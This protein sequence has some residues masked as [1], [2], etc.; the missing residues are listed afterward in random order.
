MKRFRFKCA[1]VVLLFLCIIPQPGIAE[2]CT[3]KDREYAKFSDNYYDPEEAYHFGK[4]IQALVKKKDLE[5]IFSYVDGE[6]NNG[7]RRSFAYSKGFDGTFPAEWIQSVSTDTPPCSPVGWRGF[8]LGSGLI[9]YNIVDDKWRI[10]SINGAVEEKNPT[11]AGWSVEGKLAHPQCLFF[12]RVT[13]NYIAEFA[14]AFKIK[15]ID[16]FFEH[17]GKFFGKQIRDYK[18]IRPS[19]CCNKK[20][21]L[22][23][24]VKPIKQCIP[25]SY[26]HERSSHGISTKTTDEYGTILEEAYTLLKKVSPEKCSEL[27]P[28]IGSPCTESYLL[29]AGD[30]SG[31]TMGWD[32]STGIYGLFDLPELGPSIVP[33]RFFENDNEGL[34]FLE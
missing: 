20:C 25:D 22:I 19:W 2:I 27:A 1:T 7:P 16:V 4:I 14:R 9:W 13:G 15:D 23:S 33:L 31:G 12:T 5:G 17:P 21:E 26:Q 30:Y 29:K 34:Q 10:I 28:H 11:P 24:M 32:M 6:L 18:P 8:M 3:S